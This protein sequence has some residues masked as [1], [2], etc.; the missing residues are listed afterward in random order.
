[1]WSAAG[2]RTQRGR[3]V[4][5]LLFLVVMLALLPATASAQTRRIVEMGITSPEM[6]Q[7]FQQH[8]SSQDIARV[9]HPN[10]IGLIGGIT[11]GEKMV[12]FK[13]AAQIQQF[14]ASNANAL[15][16]IGYNL[17]P[18]QQH[19]PAELANPVSAAKNVRAI[20]DRYGKLLAIG[21]TKSLTNQYAVAMA[22]YAH[23]WIL[24]VQKAQNSPQEVAAWVLPMAKALKAANPALEVFVQIRTDSDPQ[25]LRKLVDGLGTHVSIL[26]QRS[27]V[28]DAVNVAGQFFGGQQQV[29]SGPAQPANFQPV[30]M[31]GGSQYG[32]RVPS[33]VQGWFA[34]V[35][36]NL[37]GSNER[38]HLGRGSVKAWDWST[39]LRSPVF[40]IGPGVVKYAGCNDAGH[41][42]CWVQID[43]S[44][45]Y[46]SSSAHCM[47]NS[48][49]VRQGQQVDASTQI[50]NIGRTGWTDWPHVHLVIKKDG[51]HQ[52]ISNFFD[53]SLVVYC[54]FTKC[55]AD[56][57][58]NAPIAGMGTQVTG[59]ATSQQATVTTS[60]GQQLLQALAQLPAEQFGLL[61]AVLVFL[62]MFVFWLSGL[63]IRVALVSLTAAGLA[64]GCVAILFM[65]VQVQ[66]TTAQPAQM[67]SGATWDTAFKFMR[68][69]EGSKCTHDPVRTFKGVTNSAYN[70]WRQSKGLTPG[71]VCRD[72]TDEQ[73]QQIYYERYWLASG[74]DKLSAKTAIAVFDHAVNAGVGAAK[75]LLSQCGDNATCVIQARYAD[76]RTK[77]NFNVYGRAWFNR[78][79][80]LV[81]FLQLVN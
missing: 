25:A 34:P 3:R 70:A 6:A 78:V 19:D 67:A 2:I 7:Y 59:Q 39:A 17:E 53:T 44:N 32:I 4:K 73:M 20:A 77:S 49:Q 10:D 51:V 11:V 72:M 69:W 28:Q 12:I 75:G 26:T 76:Y 66:A 63:Y 18:G 27:D 42:G 61:V 5:R 80:D 43:H 29:A 48:I 9:D 8:A 81:K 55:K 38:D 65:P 79:N 33:K 52:E 16:I 54:H 41:Y 22:P 30:A 56:N 23:L 47:E 24:Q 45:G 31:A 35:A 74:A 64:A 68:R 62:F 37:I 1:M 58:P 46:Q 15:D 36:S 60:K 71:D 57:D 40:A 14:M 13:S 21:L 50:C